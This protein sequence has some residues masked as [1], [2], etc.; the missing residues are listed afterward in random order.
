MPRMF[1]PAAIG[2]SAINMPLGKLQKL[3]ICFYS[4]LIEAN[5]VAQPPYPTA[6]AVAVLAV[7]VHFAKA[8]IG[9]ILL[10]RFHG[11]LGN[12]P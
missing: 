3:S 4:K 8:H 11:G 5:D 9:K 7:S 2:A 12:A 10:P 1:R 6:M